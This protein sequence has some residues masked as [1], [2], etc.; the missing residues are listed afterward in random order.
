MATSKRDRRK[1]QSLWI[2]HLK[3]NLRCINAD[4]F[5]HGEAIT[6]AASAEIDARRDFDLTRRNGQLQEDR[7]RQEIDE[8]KKR[9]TALVEANQE[10]NLRNFEKI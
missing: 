1:E 7:L 5:K 4:I 10:V 9:L 3:N 8:M 6:Q 2:D